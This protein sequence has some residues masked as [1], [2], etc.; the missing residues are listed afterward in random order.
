MKCTICGK[1]ALPSLALCGPCKAALKRARYVTVQ[2]DRRP[3]VRAARRTTP[4][5]QSPAPRVGPVA[6]PAEVTKSRA[7]DG[8]TGRRALSVVLVVAV[9][10]GVAWFGQ[11]ELR[12][13]PP[14]SES[15]LPST[16]MESTRIAAPIPV[17]AP[18]PA[19]TPPVATPP[20]ATNANANAPTAAAD[21]DQVV[22][23]AIKAG[24]KGGSAKRAVALFVPPATTPPAELPEV[25]AAAPEPPA[26]VATPR[27]PPDRWQTM[28]DALVQ[29]DREGMLGGLVCGQ[30]VR[31]QYCEGYW[32]QVAQ[33]PGAAV[34]Y[35]K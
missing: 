34:V 28:R 1:S 24:T 26:P 2:E 8:A 27:P 33:C 18:L 25:P 3:S 12:A 32:G 31:M 4:R 5:K 10:G 9:L 7:R 20:V 14:S 21:G 13:V 22:A 35:G 30:R 23:P 11:Q 15:V 19:V 6:P 16:H 29:C 17:A